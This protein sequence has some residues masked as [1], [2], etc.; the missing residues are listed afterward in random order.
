M[1]NE[2]KLEQVF[3]EPAFPIEYEE[4]N[5]TG[6]LCKRQEFGMSKLEYLTSIIVSGLASKQNGLAHPK[7]YVKEAIETA[8]EILKQVNNY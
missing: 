7:G 1:S 4:Y 2:E 3:L 6:L 5:S 8:K